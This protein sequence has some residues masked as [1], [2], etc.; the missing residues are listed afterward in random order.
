M[1]QIVDVG[2]YKPPV[3]KP[4]APTWQDYAYSAQNIATAKNMIALAEKR[5][6]ILEA[7]KANEEYQISSP[8]KF[9]ISYLEGGTWV[10]EAELNALISKEQKSKSSNQTILKNAQATQAKLG[11]KTTTGGGTT[12][13]NKGAATKITYKKTVIFNAS[14]AKENYFKS[15][16]T[17]FDNV[18]REGT[19]A[20]QDNYVFAANTPSSLI[21]NA[22]DLWVKS[23]GSKGMVQTWEPP[24]NVKFDGD[25]ALPAGAKSIQKYGFQFLYNPDKISMSYGGVPDVDPSMMSSGKEEYL[26]SNPSVFKSGISFSILLNRTFDIKHL[27]TGGAIKGG[28]DASKIWEGNVPDQKERKRIYDYGTMYDV[29]YL[30][31]SMLRYEL[32]SQLRKDATADLGY[33]GGFPVE[34]HLGNKLRYVV[35]ISDIQINHRI[36]DARMVPIYSELT[37]TANR[38]PDYAA[39]TVKD[40]LKK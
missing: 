24:G 16:Q 38:M 9:L 10:T 33:L 1:A 26:L 31:K 3:I 30:L 35:M 11:T 8:K 39:G 15:T 37:I 40:L 13:D 28:V 20:N 17:F 6:A 4:A 2:S 36:F 19:V 22:A 32:K 21:K 14:S 29:E 5:L 25:W 34:L 27:T 18:V 23:L 7:A 12:G